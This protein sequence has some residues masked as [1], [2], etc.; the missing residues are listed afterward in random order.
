MKNS[1]PPMFDLLREM[2]EQDRLSVVNSC[3]NAHQQREADAVERTSE[4]KSDRSFD[5]TAHQGNTSQDKVESYFSP[6]SGTVI[7][8]GYSSK[9]NCRA[10]AHAL[11]KQTYVVI[12]SM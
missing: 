10:M 7:A 11:C 9:G 12:Q 5:T 3:P 1:A 4:T 6:L 8:M 2:V